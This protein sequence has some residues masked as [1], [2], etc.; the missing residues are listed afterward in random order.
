MSD[1]VTLYQNVQLKITDR[2][3]SVFIGLAQESI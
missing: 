2:E 1:G 3:S